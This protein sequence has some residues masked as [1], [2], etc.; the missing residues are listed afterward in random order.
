[1]TTLTEARMIV[2]ERDGY[3]CVC[4]DASVIG[5]PY[6]LGYRLQAAYGGRPVPSNLLTLLDRCRKR[7]DS[8]VDPQDEA[9]GYRLGPGQDPAL[10]PVMYAGGFR[11]WLTDDGALLYEAPTGAFAAAAVQLLAERGTSSLN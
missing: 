9:N 3:K 7:I 11:A 6:S 1:M 4:C 10:I 8:A 2:V 5:R